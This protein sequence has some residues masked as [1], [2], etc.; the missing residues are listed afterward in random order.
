MRNILLALAVIVPFSAPSFAQDGGIRDAAAPDAAIQSYVVQLT[1]FRLKA[2]VDPTLKAKEIV[3]AFDKLKSDGKIDLIET[4]RLSAL[5]NHE[6]MAQFGKTATVTTSISQT[7][8]GRVRSTQQREVGTMVEL[9]AIPRNGKILLKLHY[10]AS[11]FDGAGTED[12][13]P[14]TLT[15]RFNTTLLVEPGTPTLVGG[16]TAGATSLLFVSIAE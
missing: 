5:E 4:V 8:R 9:T 13:P 15:T 14:D 7:Q 2:S 11:R 6:S 3:Q 10:E 16:T 12:S 1:E